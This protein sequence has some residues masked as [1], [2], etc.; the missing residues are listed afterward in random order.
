M[1][2]KVNEVANKT[3]MQMSPQVTLWSAEVKAF[4]SAQFSLI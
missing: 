1:K 2:V 3:I 4:G